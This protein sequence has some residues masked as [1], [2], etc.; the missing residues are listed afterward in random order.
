M[1]DLRT[2][3]LAGLK[4]ESFEELLQTAGIPGNYFYRRSFATWDVLLPSEEIAK[5][6][7]THNI[8]TK[9]FRLQP[10]YRRKRRINVTVC[11][12][13]MQ[14]NGDVIAAYLSSYGGVEDYTQIKSAH[15]TA[16]GDF[17]FTMILDRGGF[18]TIPHII[19]YRDKTMTVIVEGRKP[20]CWYC[21]Q[22][23]HFSRS[24]PQKAIIATNKTTITANDTMNTTTKTTTT[25][26]TAAK[27]KHQRKPGNRGPTRKRRRVDPSKRGQ[28][29]KKHPQQKQQKL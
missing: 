15:G 5:K 26:T 21:K 24:C 11:N 27:K 20:L 7:A 18:N 29:E 22:L 6:L 28:K 23:G 17:S 1:T 12:V 2:R 14:L 25:T 13:S 16:Y 19:S 9:Y 4:K 8:T 3:R 10:E